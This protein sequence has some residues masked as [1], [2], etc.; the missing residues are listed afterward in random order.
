MKKQALERKGVV[1]FHS[2]TSDKEGKDRKEE[3]RRYNKNPRL[4][5]GKFKETISSMW[6]FWTSLWAKKAEKGLEL[7]FQNVT[8]SGLDEWKDAEKDWSPTSD[9]RKHRIVVE[10]VGMAFPRDSP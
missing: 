10:P 1:L 8:G 3:Q 4:W 2:Q 6:E 5:S 7:L 9:C